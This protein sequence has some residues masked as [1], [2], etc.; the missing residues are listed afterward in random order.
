MICIVYLLELVFG[1]ISSFSLQLLE[2]FDK[3]CRNFCY[4]RKFANSHSFG[5]SADYHGVCNATSKC[6]NILLERDKLMLVSVSS[7]QSTRCKRAQLSA[8]FAA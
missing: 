5:T 8:K 1:G 6:A 7:L 3:R 4:E 2:S